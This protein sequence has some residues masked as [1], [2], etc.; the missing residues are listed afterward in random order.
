MSGIVQLPSR[1]RPQLV[2]H[3]G[4][5]ALE[6][7]FP[8]AHSGLGPH[9][10]VELQNPSNGDAIY[11]VPANK[12]FT[13]IVVLIGAVPSGASLGLS[14]ASGGTQAVVSATGSTV[15][16]DGLITPVTIAGGGSGN[17]LTAVVTGAPWGTSVI[18]DG[19]LR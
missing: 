16:P 14:A 8:T 7:S 11:T 9:V 10:H 15:R 4:G 13:G 5:G 1:D 3:D 18:L 2:V 12:T 19:Y 6:F 17:A